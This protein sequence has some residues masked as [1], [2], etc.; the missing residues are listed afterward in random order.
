[1]DAMNADGVLI[2]S[3]LTQTFIAWQEKAEE[4]NK[5]LFSLSK[6]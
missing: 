1:M 6:G 4:G 3:H 2:L 5:Q